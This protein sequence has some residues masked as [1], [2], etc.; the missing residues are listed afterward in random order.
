MLQNLYGNY[1]SVDDL[2]IHN[3]KKTHKDRLEKNIESII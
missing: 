2:L 1:A 3:R